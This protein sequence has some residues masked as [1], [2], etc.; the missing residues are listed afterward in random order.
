ALVK[1]YV[2]CAKNQKKNPITSILI[3]NIAR[4]NVQSSTNNDNDNSHDTLPPAINTSLPKKARKNI[5]SST[6]NDNDNSQNHDT[7][8]PAIN[9]LLPKKAPTINV[10]SSKSVQSSRSIRRK[11]VSQGTLTP[12]MPSLKKSLRSSVQKDNGVENTPKQDGTIKNNAQDSSTLN[13]T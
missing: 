7:L 2:H 4:K 6:N 3:I 8:P 11:N 9:T 1:R 12:V 10:L 5:Q 13:N